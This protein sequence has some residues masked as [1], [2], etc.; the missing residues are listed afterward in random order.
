MRELPAL[1]GEI[2][3]GDEES[4]GDATAGNCCRGSFAADVFAE[5]NHVER[6]FKMKFARFSSCIAAVVIVDAISEI[7]ALLNFA[8]DEA[9]ADGVGGASG[10]EHRIARAQRYVLQRVLAGGGGN[11]ALESCGG[12]IGPQADENFGDRKSTR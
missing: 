5:T 2:A 11:A 6:F 9:S 1:S 3:A 7:G 8:E 4:L 10:D 12:D